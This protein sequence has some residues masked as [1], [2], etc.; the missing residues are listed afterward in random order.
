[1]RYT[2][3]NI[4]KKI[5]DFFED[6]IQLSNRKSVITDLITLLFTAID[7]GILDINEKRIAPNIF[8]IIIDEQLK[9]DFSAFGN[10]LKD[11]Q[12]LI[13]EV[14]SENDFVRQGPLT[15]QIKWVEN[16]L[17]PISVVA[18]HTNAVS[19]HTIQLNR[20]VEVSDNMG[21]DLKAMLLFT[22]GEKYQLHEGLTTIGRGIENDLTI[23]NLLLSRHHARI[24]IQN[25][26]T[27][28]TD[29]N[30]INGTFV[31]GNKI[32]KHILLSGDVLTLG[33]ISMIYI[34]DDESENNSPTTIKIELE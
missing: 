11:L 5:S 34:T 6:H 21:T 24:T 9:A 13:E 26:Q 15:I 7:E 18:N 23:D 4:E 20:K 33:D 28:I 27:I 22:D 8:T 29:L 32:E 30:S 2:L 14:I 25:N 16:Q 10:W 1:M 31:N 3:V 19:G 17:K 12:G